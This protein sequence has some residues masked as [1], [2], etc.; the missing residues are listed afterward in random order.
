M[1]STVL[2]LRKGTSAQTALFTGLPGE[3]TVNTTKNAV[4]VHDGVTPGGHMGVSESEVSE[5]A[6]VV[7]AGDQA[8][9]AR[10]T[11]V[12]Q[13]VE[14]IQTAQ[15]A[16]RIWFATKAELEADLVHESGTLADVTDDSVASNNGLYQKSGL[17][18]TGTWQKKA[19]SP[20]TAL[21]AEVAAMQSSITAINADM[22]DLTASELSVLARGIVAIASGARALKI[23]E[24]K[25]VFCNRG[26]SADVTFILP[27]PSASVEGLNFQFLQLSSSHHLCISPGAGQFRGRN[28][29]DTDGHRLMSDIVEGSVLNVIC[30]KNDAGVYHWYTSG[31]GEWDDVDA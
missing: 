27:E 30:L 16:G 18:G 29:T 15:I 3:V 17:P 10:V 25:M 1:G 20:T 26:S 6:S 14:S 5:L 4:V 8:L 19:D 21:S 11:T 9:D 31:I 24:G 12:E 13:T 28:P 7:A 2:Q 23:W 22:A